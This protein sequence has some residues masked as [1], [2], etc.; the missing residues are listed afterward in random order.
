VTT[1]AGGK[2]TGFALIVRGIGFLCLWVVMFG[3]HIPDLWV[4]VAAAGAAAWTSVR[5]LPPGGA[6]LRPGALARF[7]VRFFAQSA[8][9]G[10]DVAR[11]ALDPALPLRPGFVLCPTRLP[12]GSARDAFCTIASLLPGTLPVGSDRA[13]ALLVHCLDAGK[14]VPAEIAEEEAAFRATLRGNDG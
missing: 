11:R 12:P 3:T 2:G 6:R 4:G 10:A 14:D 5:L 1:P 13:G 8:V 9:A 7:V